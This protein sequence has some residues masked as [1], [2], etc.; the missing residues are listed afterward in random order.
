MNHILSKGRLLGIGTDIIYLP[1]IN[2]LLQKYAVNPELP[3]SRFYKIAKKFMHPVELSKLESLLK[4]RDI[5]DA[6]VVT[7][8][9]GI[10]AAKESTYKA[11][12]CFV[13][14]NMIPPAQSVY[15]RLVYK[16]NQGNGV[17]VLRFDERFDTDPWTGSKFYK[18]YIE[19]PGTKPLIS[20]SHDRDYLISFVTLMTE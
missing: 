10:W 13:P 20:I 18:Q 19:G 14:H 12:S 7:Y 16:T 1:R 11:L 2:K 5:A 3:R 4:Q 8:V 6:K 17:P 15:T 9:G